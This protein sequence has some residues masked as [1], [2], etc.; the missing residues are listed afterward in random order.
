MGSLWL[1]TCTVF[2]DKA[3]VHVQSS[4]FVEHE[5]NKPESHT[6][7]WSPTFTSS[8]FGYFFRQRYGPMD[9][10]PRMPCIL[11]RVLWTL[12]Y[13][14]AFHFFHNTSRFLICIF[15]VWFQFKSM[16]YITTHWSVCLRSFN[17]PLVRFWFCWFSCSHLNDVGHDPQVPI[18][19]STHLMHLTWF[20]RLPASRP[21]RWKLP[22]RGAHRIGYDG[23]TQQI[24]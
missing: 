11:I 3:I 10:W 17:L 6:E 14:I 12:A 21:T 7:K 22:N 8:T 19:Q 24:H 2:A 9:M 15:Y 1:D 5:S 16:Q 20:R 18:S 4:V 23:S 13:L